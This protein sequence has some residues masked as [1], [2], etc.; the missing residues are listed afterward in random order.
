MIDKA[1]ENALNQVIDELVCFAIAGWNV[2]KDKPIDQEILIQQCTQNGKITREQILSS[3]KR[4]TQDE[5]I[6]FK[7]GWSIRSR[8]D[9]V[10]HAFK[11]L[12]QEA[13]RAKGEKI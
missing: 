11:Q 3:L 4:L 10:E 7:N 1:K 12:K 2:F 6:I 8:T 5:S 13:L 9:T